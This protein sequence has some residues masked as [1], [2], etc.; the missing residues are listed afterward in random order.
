[1]KTGAI[2]GNTARMFA[3][4]FGKFPLVSN[5]SNKGFALVQSFSGIILFPFGTKHVQLTTCFLSNFVCRV[6][7]NFQTP[8]ILFHTTL[9]FISVSSSPKFSRTRNFIC[10][11]YPSKFA[12]FQFFFFNFLVFL[13]YSSDIFIKIRKNYQSY[14]PGLLFQISRMFNV[15]YP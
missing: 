14:L 8:S 15:I 2:E 11:A 10:P 5:H 12:I 9:D 4:C 6:F 13:P 3:N 7:T 1:M